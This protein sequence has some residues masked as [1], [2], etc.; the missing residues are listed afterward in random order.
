[1]PPVTTLCPFFH[2]AGDTRFDLLDRLHVDQ[3]PY[4]RTRLEPV[5]DLHR[6]GGP[7]EALVKG[8]IDAVPHQDAA[9]AHTGLTGIEYFDAMAPLTAISIS[10][11]SRATDKMLSCE[12]DKK[13]SKHI[14]YYHYHLLY[15]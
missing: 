15:R 12:S 10:K 1:V 3:W 7:G 2:R 5:G 8:V 11:S 13:I 9:G 4:D 14:T 6:P